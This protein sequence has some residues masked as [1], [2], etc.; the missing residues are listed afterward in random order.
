MKL[1][2]ITYLLQ[3]Y[4][5]TNLCAG[6]EIQW[7]EKKSGKEKPGKWMDPSRKLQGPPVHQYLAASDGLRK[8][9]STQIPF[10]LPQGNSVHTEDKETHVK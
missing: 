9:S 10:S 2:S 4:K 1:K 6:T 7:K 5:Y 3:A 8:S